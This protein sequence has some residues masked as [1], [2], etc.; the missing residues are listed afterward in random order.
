VARDLR[1]CL[2]SK[3]W[4]MLQP[5]QNPLSQLILSAPLTSII[6]ASLVP[7]LL[8]LSFKL[9]YYRLRMAQVLPELSEQFDT[10]LIWVNGF[11]FS[12]GLGIGLTVAARTVRFVSDKNLERSDEAGGRVLFYGLLVS[13]LTLSLWTFAGLVY[14]VALDLGLEIEAAWSFYGHFLSTLALCGFAAMAYPYF[15]LTAL[16]VRWFFPAMMRNNMVLGPRWKDL[17]RLRFWNRVHLALAGLV[18]MLAVML[19]TSSSGSENHATLLLVSG[20]GVMGFAALFA[21]ERL[22]DGDIA[23]LERIAVDELQAG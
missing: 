1:L 6:V 12:I 3:T 23:A 13:L 22:I 14:P 7:N 8:I 20:G 18:P 19:V 5:A 21:L 2:H 4:K 11:A 16:A 15:L 9:Y 17:Q 10:V